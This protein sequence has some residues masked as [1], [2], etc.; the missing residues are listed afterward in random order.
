MMAGNIQCFMIMAFRSLA[1]K[2]RPQTF[3]SVIGQDAVIDVLRGAFLQKK[4]P[5]CILLSGTRGIG[6]TTIARLIARSLSCVHSNVEQ[7]PCGQCQPCQNT[8]ADPLD[9]VELDAASHTGVDDIRSIL[10]ACQYRPMVAS[11]KVFIVDEAHMLSKSAFNALLK[12]LE[13]PPETVVFILATTESDKLPLTILSRC[14]KL[15]LSPVSNAVLEKHYAQICADEQCSIQPQ[16]LTRIV[17]AAKGSVRDG[18]SLLDQALLLAR[19]KESEIITL[20][21][22]QSML[23]LQDWKDSAQILTYVIEKDSENLVQ[24]LQNLE[25]RGYSPPHVLEDL[26]SLIHALSQIHWGKKPL[27]FSEDIIETLHH[28]AQ[29]TDATFVGQLWQMTLKGWKDVRLAFLPSAALEMALLRMIVMRQFPSANELLSCFEQETQTTSKE[30]VSENTSSPKH[31]QSSVENSDSPHSPWTPKNWDD[32]LLRLEQKREA[33]LV[34]MAKKYLAIQSWSPP[35]IQAFVK[36]F[37]GESDPWIK[38]VQN[39]LC[40][41]TGNPWVLKILDNADMDKMQIMTQQEQ[42]E[43]KQQ[44]EKEKFVQSDLSAALLEAF[45]QATLEVIKKT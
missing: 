36:N 20:D 44:Q 19:S 31:T 41:E 3:E 45:P 38:R 14:L 42:E 5:A 22:V 8:G 35:K 27:T 34:V 17:Q 9:I 43:A 37:Q 23:G 6:K 25:T 39:F 7:R 26:A 33:Y 12:T 2:T 11:H 15:S 30:S 40:E 32:V 18:L 10:D 29:K 21:S 24:F 13:D 4:I 28:L 16:A 1:Q